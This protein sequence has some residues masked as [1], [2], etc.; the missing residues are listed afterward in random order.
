MNEINYLSFFF[1]VA[2]NF[3]FKAMQTIRNRQFFK[4]LTSFI[5]NYFMIKNPNFGGKYKSII[6][7]MDGTSVD[8]SSVWELATEKYLKKK[9]LSF[10]DIIREKLKALTS[11][12]N[13][14]AIKEVTRLKIAPKKLWKELAKLDII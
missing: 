14:S 11:I 2:I 1:A 5:R 12:K 6:F 4:T 13:G 9:G 10:D 8:T 3:Q 7:D